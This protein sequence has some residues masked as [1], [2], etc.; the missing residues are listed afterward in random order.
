MVKIGIIGGSGLENP[1]ILKNAQEK[2]VDTEFGRPASHLVIGKIEGIDVVIVSRHGRKH[3]IMPTNVPNRANIQALKNEGCTHIIATT[4]C[5]SLKKEIKPGDFVF[6]DQF[7]D[8]TTKRIST[9]WEKDKVCHIPMA[10]PFCRYMRKLLKESAEKLNLSFHEKGTV[11]TIEGPRFSTRAESR[12]WQQWNADVINMSTVP[13][14]VLAREAGLCYASI[15]MATDYDC[16]EE[17][18]EVNVAEVVTTFK[19]NVGKVIKLLLAVIPIIEM[20]EKCK[21]RHDYKY[22]FQSRE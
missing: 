17:G 6:I 12:L 16:F 9:F 13:E 7:I 14:V 19:N 5:G 15:A 10:E 3:E 18:R 8:R 20:N 22:S 11:V 2:D 21:C 4:A 1:E